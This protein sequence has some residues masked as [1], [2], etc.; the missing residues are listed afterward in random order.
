MKT[1][2][3]ELTPEVRNKILKVIQLQ[4]IQK[5]STFGSSRWEEASKILGGLYES[6]AELKAPHQDAIL[7]GE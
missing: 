7:W 5:T 4:H 1:K 2:A 3:S 6:L